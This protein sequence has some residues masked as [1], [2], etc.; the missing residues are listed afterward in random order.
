[1]IRRRRAACD[2]V[3]IEGL[4]RPHRTTELFGV[5][6]AD[7]ALRGRGQHYEEHLVTSAGHRDDLRQQ[8]KDN[9]VRITES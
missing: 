5:G 7:A 4:L 9:R 6:F 3:T 1:M 2:A 8:A